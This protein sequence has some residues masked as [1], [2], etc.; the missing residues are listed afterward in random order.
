MADAEHE[1]LLE[2]DEK[3]SKNPAPLTTTIEATRRP[4]VSVAAGLARK[5]AAESRGE[6]LTPIWSWEP[7][8][9]PGGKMSLS[10]LVRKM[11]TASD[12]GTGYDPKEIAE[13]AKPRFER[14]VED[15]HSSSGAHALRGLSQFK[16]KR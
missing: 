11:K 15:R 10:D 2:A 9:K 1:A 16:K 14:N 4:V 7:A 8:N 6:R 13:G 3:A 5:S 12:G